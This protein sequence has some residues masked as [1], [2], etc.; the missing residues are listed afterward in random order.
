MFS[1]FTGGLAATL[2]GDVNARTALKRA[3]GFAAHQAL[4]AA[5]CALCRADPAVAASLLEDRIAADGGVG[6]MGET[7]GVAPYLIEAYVA[8]GRH[9]DA[10]AVAE[11]FAAVTP[12]TAPPWRRAL[13]A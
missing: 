4:T 8:L 11:Q 12:A 9:D 6:S 5:F 7:L 1:D 10:I 13:V 3:T 2:G